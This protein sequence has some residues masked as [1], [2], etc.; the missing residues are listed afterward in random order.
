MMGKSGNNAANYLLDMVPASSNPRLFLSNY[1]LTGPDELT[2]RAAV[3]ED[4]RK[5]VYNATVSFLGGISGL[6]TLHAAWAVTKMYYT[7]FYVARAALCRS[8][9]VIF[10]VPKQGSSGHTQYKLRISAGEQAKIVDKPRST[11]KLAAAEFRQTGYPSFMQG[12]EIDGKDPLEW[13]MEQREYWQYRAGRFPDPD[14]PDVLRKFGA[15]SAPRLL[16]EYENDAIGVFLA[17]PDHALI[18][19]P[20][21]LLLWAMKADSLLSPGVVDEEDMAHLS[22][23]CRIGGNQLTAIHRL[24]SS[25]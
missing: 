19:V 4:A 17:D 5:H 22:R 14:L 3:T 20:F 9:L 23:C 24:L 15:G 6:H 18:A 7:V 10:H 25:P 11:H 2:L 21:R 16:A 12:L 8:G 1:S 13:L